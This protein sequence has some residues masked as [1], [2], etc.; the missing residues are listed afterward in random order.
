MRFLG[1]CCVELQK[2]FLED[3][4]NWYRLEDPKQLRFSKSPSVSP[5]GSLANPGTAARE[6]AQR[7]L[8]RGD[9]TTQRSYSGKQK[10]SNFAATSFYI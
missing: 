5:R 8:R 4:P 7:L 6:I 9:F 1:E 2:A 3:R 10:L